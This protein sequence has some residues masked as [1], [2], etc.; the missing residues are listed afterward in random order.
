MKRVY[1]LLGKE[2]HNNSKV[3]EAVTPI[4]EEFQ[5]LFPNTS[6]ALT[7]LKHIRHLIDLELGSTVPN[8]P[9]YHMSPTKHEESRQLSRRVT[10]KGIYS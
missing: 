7:L 5:D 9:Y 8:R 4:L 3:L 10:R 2:S 1:N 6:Q